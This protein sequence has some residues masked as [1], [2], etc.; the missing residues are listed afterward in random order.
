ME[1]VGAVAFGIGRVKVGFDEYTVHAYGNTD[2]DNPKQY[3][4]AKV[5][6][7]ITVKGEATQLEDDM[8]IRVD[9]LK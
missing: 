5:G 3:R 7:Q 1:H 6:D 9:E 4:V 8:L 2:L